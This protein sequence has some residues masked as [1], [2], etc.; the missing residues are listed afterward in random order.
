[1]A[2]EKILVIEDDKD[3][4]ELL[5]YNLEK[6]NF[7]VLAATNGEKGLDVVHKNP[8]ALI[9]LDLMLPHID[10]LELCKII[11]KDP[12]TSH[13]PIIMLTAKAEESDKIVGLELGADDYVTKPFSPRELIA[14][15][16]ALFRR[17]YPEAKAQEIVKI[18]EVI[19]DFGK[20]IVKQKGRKVKLTTKEF[21][22]LK[23]LIEAKGKVVSRENLLENVWGYENSMDITTRTIDVHMRSIREKLKSIAARFITVRDVGYRLDTES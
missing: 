23:M 5:K 4:T 10:G 8:P 22:L 6:E 21:G 15:I 3:I 20:Y 17:L 16:K 13:I 1:M 18:D 11:K 12:K 19:I 14:R 7:Q 9:I 2:R